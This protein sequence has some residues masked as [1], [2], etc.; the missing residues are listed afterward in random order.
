MEFVKEG[1]IILASKKD[2][3]VISASERE[4]LERSRRDRKTLTY[5]REA[6]K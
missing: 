3:S 5:S 2:H 6:S 1:V 4:K